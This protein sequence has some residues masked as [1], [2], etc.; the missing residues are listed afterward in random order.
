MT[1]SFIAAHKFRH[2]H[3]AGCCVVFKGPASSMCRNKGPATADSGDASPGMPG[4]AS[5][6]TET[7]LS[8]APPSRRGQRCQIPPHRRHPGKV[9]VQWPCFVCGRIPSSRSL[10]V[11]IFAR[12]NTWRTNAFRAHCK[13]NAVTRPWHCNKTLVLQLHHDCSF[14]R[15]SQLEVGFAERVPSAGTILGS[16]AIPPC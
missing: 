8:T 7:Q 16:S 11:I 2:V 3:M 12:I 5:A 9:R 10:H 1:A 15:A 14:D 6:A 13:S 4:T